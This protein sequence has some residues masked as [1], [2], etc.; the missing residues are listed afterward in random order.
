[1]L[2]IFIVENPEYFQLIN[3]YYLYLKTWLSNNSSELELDLIHFN[4]LRSDTNVN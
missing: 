1:M 2:I 4:V 3:F